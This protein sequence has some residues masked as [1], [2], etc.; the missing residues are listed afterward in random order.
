MLSRF[1]LLLMGLEEA[2]RLENLGST[3]NDLARS[4]GRPLLLLSLNPVV[5]FFLV[6]DEERGRGVG[7]DRTVI[8][9]DEVRDAS[10]FMSIKV[11]IFRLV[12]SLP[13]TAAAAAVDCGEKKVAGMS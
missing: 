7:S 11:P 3:A 6:A 9:A 4:R 5:V 12:S 8:T 1:L 13:P 10:S 2:D